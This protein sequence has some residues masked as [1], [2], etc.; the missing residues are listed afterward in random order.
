MEK[1]IR[2]KI[3]LGMQLTEK[4]TAMYILY[5]ATDEELIRYL[6]KQQEANEE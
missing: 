3:T 6:L 1:T 2:A 4:E 5:Y